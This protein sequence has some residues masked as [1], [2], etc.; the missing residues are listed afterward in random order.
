MLNNNT[1][2]IPSW[3]GYKAQE[4]RLVQHL[5]K[6]PRNHSIG[7]EVLD[8]VHIESES[9]LVLEQDKVSNTSR[10]PL[11]N[12][13]TDLWKS[14]YNWIQ[15]IEQ[16]EVQISRT[17]FLFFTNKK[18]SGDVFN[19]LIE[20]SDESSAHKAVLSIFDLIPQPSKAISK[21]FAAFQNLEEKTR[22]KFICNITYEYGENIPPIELKEQYLSLNDSIEEH[23]DD[24]IR[25]LFGWVS[26][27]LTIYAAQKRPTV[28]RAE[29]FGTRKRVV[30]SSYDI[31]TGLQYICS[32]NLADAD[33]IGELS[34]TPT[35]I[36]QLH[37]I[38]LDDN[39]IAMAA[40]NKLEAKDAV[41]KWTVEGSIEESS[42][43][44]YSASLQHKWRAI[45]LDIF[46]S[47]SY[48]T[49][50]S[51]GQALYG[52]CISRSF[53]VKLENR[54]VEPFFSEGTYQVL[55]N[56]SQIGWHP[57]YVELLRNEK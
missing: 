4:Y 54:E 34:D 17:K 25:N 56:N 3:G 50:N 46:N 9:Q 33:V 45:K 30:E 20:A 1:G 22:L 24:I 16:N 51:K 49:D 40:V 6:A 21:Y 13:S 57:N 2:A 11:A 18:F 53:D 5:L 7:F 31:K 41:I 55:A 15:L 32:R 10:N 35:Y 37:L 27:V 8:D 42:Y 47:S 48:Q 43:S 29:E 36:R 39:D 26:E 12:Q 38:D 19:A 52:S 14:L 44:K 23:A 28:I